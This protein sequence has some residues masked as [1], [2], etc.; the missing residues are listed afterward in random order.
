MPLQ[1]M[2]EDSVLT[3]LLVPLIGCAGLFYINITPGIASALV[4]G[5]G[6]T[7]SQAGYVMSA[8]GMGGMAGAAIA[9]FLF[10]RYPWKIMCLVLMG[11]AFL[12]ELGTALITE[13][14]AMATWRFLA[15]LFGGTAVTV[16]FGIMG[17]MAQPV[18]AFGVLLFLQFGLGGLVLST[19]FLSEG[20]LGTYALFYITATLIFL[21]LVSIPFLPAFEQ[22]AEPEKAVLREKRPGFS[23]LGLSG[24]SLA[25]LSCVFLFQAGI[26]GVW[27]YLERMAITS[28]L[29]AVT[30]SRIVGLTV[31]LGGVGA[32]I[33]M[34]FGHRLGRRPP[35]IIGLVSLM[36]A[37]LLLLQANNLPAYIVS[38]VILNIAWA[39]TI[40][41]LLGAVA[42]SEPSG[43]ASAA[44]S[45]ASKFGIGAG[46]FISASVLAVGGAGF[47][48]VIYASLAIYA[49]CLGVSWAGLKVLEARAKHETG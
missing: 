49:A 46:P 15:G 43:R 18:R 38:N 34:L 37:M 4:T 33:P 3:Y 39:S 48:P 20:L 12:V 47:T 27:T 7:D 42:A 6:L 32:L 25:L 41:F 44:N 13:F 14:Q 16:S 11:I 28:G 45:V 30:V 10:G 24:L 29:E 5:I 23:I 9:L 8:N 35:I 40:A 26:F 21:S 19:R 36:I 17:R 22:K 31:Y 1:R 2:P